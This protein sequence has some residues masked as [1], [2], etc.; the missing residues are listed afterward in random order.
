VSSARRPDASALA[1][2]VAAH[3][4]AERG[5]SVAMLQATTDGVPVYERLGFRTIS[6]FR[7]SQI[8]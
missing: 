5:H 6:A 7:S 2:L 8:V 1:T 4:G 3:A